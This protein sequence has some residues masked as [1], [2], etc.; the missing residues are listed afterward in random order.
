[1]ARGAAFDKGACDVAVLVTSARLDQ[2]TARFVLEPIGFPRIEARPAAQKCGKP[3]REYALS[4]SGLDSQ[5]AL[6]ALSEVID[7]ALET[8]DRFLT[9][10][11]IAFA[12][13]PAASPGPIADKRLKAKP[14]ERMLAKAVT[15]TQ[16]LL[17]SVAPIRRDD[18]KEVRYQGEVSFEAVVGV[19]GR[20][21][22]S[23]L[24]ASLG[25]N[26]DRVLKALELWRYEPARRGDEAVGLRMDERTTFR[27][28]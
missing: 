18:R 3:P 5:G 1:L 11:G 27:V 21:H 23:R 9:E 8:P 17:L 28:F 15:R 22:D 12:L 25:A 20:L 10:R 14:E 26:A 16:Q 24:D 2:G 13:K 7:G 19:D 6:A 4:I